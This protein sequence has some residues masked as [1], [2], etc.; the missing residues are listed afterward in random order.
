MK[1][2]SELCNVKEDSVTKR[3]ET[4]KADLARLKSAVEKM[5]NARDVEWACH[6]LSGH[7][8]LRHCD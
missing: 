7:N 2:W 5:D 4:V 8:T 6:F 3:L 1:K